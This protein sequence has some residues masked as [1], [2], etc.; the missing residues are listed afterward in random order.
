MP[1]PS[2]GAGNENDSFT[3]AFS[4][5]LQKNPLLAAMPGGV[6]INALTAYGK[7]NKQSGV[8][9]NYDAPKQQE[10][11]DSGSSRN[12]KR[13][14]AGKVKANSKET[15]PLAKDVDENLGGNEAVLAPSRKRSNRQSTML[16]GSKGIRGGAN[17][18]RT[19]LGA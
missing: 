10:S 16:T 1:G 11:G 18:G 7:S 6:A 5:N 12:P 2:A 15:A 9:A 14:V 8:P 3:H 17:I 13:A 19:L 4:R